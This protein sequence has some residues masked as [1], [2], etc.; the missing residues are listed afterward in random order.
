MF[1]VMRKPPTRVTK[2]RILVTAPIQ[3]AGKSSEPHSDY[4][5]KHHSAAHHANLRP[6]FLTDGNLV[7]KLRLFLKKKPHS[8]HS[9]E[10][11]C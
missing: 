4:F 7:N 5:T 10:R 11:V 3:C 6:E 2:E 8:F 9:S 1:P